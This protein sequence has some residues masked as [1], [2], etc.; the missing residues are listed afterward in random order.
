[1]STAA[2]LSQNLVEAFLAVGA[3]AVISRHPQHTADLSAA[4]LAAYFRELYTALFDKQCS[5]ADAV[6]AA[7]EPPAR[8]FA[9]QT[10]Q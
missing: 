7:G 9:L 1:M 10:R 5:T 3:T 2:V 8:Q 6:H 4:E